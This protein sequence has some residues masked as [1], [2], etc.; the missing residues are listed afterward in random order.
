MIRL[1]RFANR[2]PLL[3]QQSACVVT[4][5]AINTSWRNYGLSQSTGA[6]PSGPILLM[7]HLASVWVP[8]TSESKEAI[9]HYPEIE[10]EIKLALQECGR[11]VATFIKRKKKAADEFKKK[12]Y[13]K[14]Y[15][16]HIGIALKEILNLNDKQEQKVIDNLT[17]ILER[18]RS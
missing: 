16:P 9:A 3:Y 13:I 10:K 18:S 12:S 6:L 15:I 11:H 7:V 2:V 4:E 5:S 8:F 17:D 1:L 14:K